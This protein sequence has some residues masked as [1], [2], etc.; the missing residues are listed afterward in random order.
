[1]YLIADVLVTDY[2]S[3][4]FDYAILKRPIYFFMYDL[5]TYRDELR[6][7]YLDIYHDLPGDVIESED[8]LIQ[9]V[10]SEKFDYNR[11]QI[12]NEQFNNHEDGN[13]SKRVIEILLK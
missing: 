13:A 10:F 8:E 2:S 4:F 12:F 7:F 6:G 11:L 9:K 3:V 1:M 5:D